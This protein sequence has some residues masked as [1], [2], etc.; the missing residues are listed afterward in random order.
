MSAIRTKI[1][2]ENTHFAALN[3]LIRKK[4]KK[5]FKESYKM[6]VNPEDLDVDFVLPNFKLY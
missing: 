6:S 3:L 2:I 4:K 1:S 5:G